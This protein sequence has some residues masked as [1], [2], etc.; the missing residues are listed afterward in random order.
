[1][2]RTALKPCVP[3]HRNPIDEVLEGGQGAPLSVVGQHVLVPGPVPRPRVPVVLQGTQ[4]GVVR[5][6]PSSGGVRGVVREDGPGGW[7]VGRGGVAEH[8]WVDE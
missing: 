6:D 1:M 7:S 8:A 2:D 4:A 3:D 5:D